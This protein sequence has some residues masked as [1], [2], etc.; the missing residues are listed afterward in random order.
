MTEPFLTPRGK[1]YARI[2]FLVHNYC[3]TIRNKFLRNLASKF[4][5]SILA[6]FVYITILKEGAQEQNARRKTKVSRM[7]NRTG[8]SGERTSGE[9]REVRVSNQGIH[10]VSPLVQTSGE[11][12]DTNASTEKEI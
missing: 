9:M 7:P 3:S 12:Y 1:K 11:G 8:V 2:V 4:V 10:T 6:S 5:L